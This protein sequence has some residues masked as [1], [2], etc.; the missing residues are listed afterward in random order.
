MLQHQAARLCLQ[1]CQPFRWCNLSL[2]YPQ[3]PPASPPPSS[4]SLRLFPLS[5]RGHH[6]ALQQSAMIVPHITERSLCLFAAFL[7]NQGLQA[8]SITAYLSAVRH[9]QIS[10][11]LPSPTTDSWPWLHYVSRGIKCSQNQPQRVRLPITTSILKQLHSIW[12]SN[13]YGF[14]V[15]K[16]KLL[17]AVASTTF[18]ASLDSGSYCHPRAAPY[19]PPSTRPGR[20]FLRESHSVHPLNQ[21]GQ[22]DPFGKGAQVA[23][24]STHSR[25]LC[26]VNAFKEF[27]EARPPSPEPL[28][29]TENASPLLK[30]AFVSEISR[31]LETASLNPALYA[32]H[33]FRIG[34]ATS[35]VAAG[36]PAH[37]IQTLGR[38]SSD[39]FKLYIRA[40]RDSLAQ[41]SATLA[42]LSSC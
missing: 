22:N 18:S 26:P 41:V 38:W 39:A 35:A 37:M 16:A 21:E 42:S 2:P 33:S 13:N 8:S 17:W 29:I 14:P 24:G 30:E 34:A 25:P 31:A 23:L 9:L 12:F 28:V 5:L 3:L 11:G 4:A 10:A 15:Y 1:P 7:A 36:I 32:G 6:A 27:L 19:P 40:S 20:R